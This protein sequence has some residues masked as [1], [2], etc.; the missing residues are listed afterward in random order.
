MVAAVYSIN[1]ND[2]RF[3]TELAW[4]AWTEAPDC[5][6]ARCG[7]ALLHMLVTAGPA[8]TGADRFAGPAS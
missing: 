1:L 6:S 3:V 7:T 5:P 8:P 4:M 2:P